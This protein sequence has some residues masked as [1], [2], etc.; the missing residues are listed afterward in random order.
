MHVQDYEKRLLVK[1]QEHRASASTID[2]LRRQVVSLQRDV[3][4]WKES[5][6]KKELEVSAAAA[7]RDEGTKKILRFVAVLIF[8]FFLSIP[9]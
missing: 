1:D 8:S 6:E 5:A 4:H 7:A 3:E 9:R 2:Q